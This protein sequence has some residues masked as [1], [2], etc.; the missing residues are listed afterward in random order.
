MA[1]KPRDVTAVPV[2]SDAV[3]VALVSECSIPGRVKG[4][5]SAAV[6]TE[7]MCSVL[8]PQL[9]KTSHPCP[10][11][12][13]GRLSANSATKLLVDDPPWLRIV[14]DGSPPAMTKRPK[15]KG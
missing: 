6:L 9:A 10:L 8:V 13:S 12:F 14:H 5:A 2:G 11:P 15:Q 1:V 7:W 3:P 4:R